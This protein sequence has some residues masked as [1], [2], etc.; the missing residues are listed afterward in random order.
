M[1]NI[2][3]FSKQ[4]GKTRAVDH[5]EFQV[6]DG[7]VCVLLGANG[8][9]KSTTI[10][11]IVG[12]LKYEGSIHWDGVSTRDSE[13]KRKISYVPE[14]P[15]LFKMLTVR[16]HV[17]YMCKAYGKEITDNEIDTLLE[18]FDMLDKQNKFGDELS[19]GM[20]QK[21]S[22]CCALAVSPDLLILD[23]P[24]VGLDPKAI[25]E[26]RDVIQSLK[27]EGKTIIISTHML[28]M[29]DALWDRV[30]MLKQGR[31]IGNYTRDEGSDKDLE[32]LYFS[33][34]VE[35]KEEEIQHEL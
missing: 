28:E 33:L 7:E 19:K 16:E 20:M 9:G 15:A 24:M 11:S 8:A 21:V 2:K 22:I 1:L 6:N 23:E 5:I 10:Q 26:L 13:T 29:V 25:K 14:I 32:D 18:R 4:Y 17:Q 12:I 34:N 27:N 31:V 3:N 30:V 35:K